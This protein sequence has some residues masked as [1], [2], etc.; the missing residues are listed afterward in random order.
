MVGLGAQEILLLGM[1]LILPLTAG[2]IIY[3]ATK[4]KRKQRD[5]EP[6]EW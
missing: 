6:D 1:L 5:D 4:K 3:L 2:V